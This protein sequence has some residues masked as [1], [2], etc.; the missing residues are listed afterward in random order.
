MEDIIDFVEDP[1]P[2]NGWRK[3]MAGMFDAVLVLAI[4]FLWY[5]LGVDYSVNVLPKTIPFE[6]AVFITFV[7]YR[8]VTICLLSKTIGMFAFRL[9]FLTAEG[10]Q[11]SLLQRAATAFFIMVKGMDYYHAK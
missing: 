8:L 2:E 3:W 11:P 4:C 10:T 7:L 5:L 1:K 9:K 6:L